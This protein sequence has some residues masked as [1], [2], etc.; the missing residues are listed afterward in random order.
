M[1]YLVTWDLNREK[2]NYADARRKFVAQLEHTKDPGLDSLWFIS[3][4]W[5]AKKVD[6]FLRQKL[7]G[8][9]RLIATQLV[10]GQHQGWLSKATWEW[11]TAR[12]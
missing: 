10:P 12:L 2:P 8:N 11:I 3:T 9:D 1:V 6:E 5:S 4:M 7:Y